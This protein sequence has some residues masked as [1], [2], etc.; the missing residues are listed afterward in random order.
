M[1]WLDK[2]LELGNSL[3]QL[4][5]PSVHEA[6]IQKYEKEKQR[7]IQEDVREL[8]KFLDDNPDNDIDAGN[9]ILRLFTKAGQP[10]G[11]LGSKRVNIPVGVLY[12][13]VVV[14]RE[15]IKL[16][17]ILTRALNK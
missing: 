12:S 1:L 4:V 16:K 3:T 10:V 14:L 6:V 13:L 5:M 17:A 15:N 2:A 9:Y 11:G 7:G 8:Q